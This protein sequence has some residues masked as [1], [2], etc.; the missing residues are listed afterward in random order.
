MR[1]CRCPLSFYKKSR[2]WEQCPLIARLDL[3]RQYAELIDVPV[4]DDHLDRG[5]HSQIAAASLG[6]TMSFL[7]SQALKLML[8]IGGRRIVIISHLTR[9]PYNPVANFRSK[10]GGEVAAAGKERPSPRPP[11]GVV[12]S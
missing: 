8:K 4:A 6:A 9:P 11:L 1:S 10:H 2:R 3:S 7:K 12:E 5:C